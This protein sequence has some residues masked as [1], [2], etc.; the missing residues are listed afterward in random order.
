MTDKFEYKGYLG[1]VKFYRND[2]LFRGRVVN[3]DNHI[4]S[5]C[6]TSISEL[7]ESLEETVEEYLAD[8][9]DE[10]IEPE[11]PKVMAIS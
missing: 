9:A 11:Q 4:I 2:Q 1:D 6:G 7:Q 10:G 5:F 3:I 8:C